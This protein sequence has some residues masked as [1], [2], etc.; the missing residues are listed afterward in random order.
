VPLRVVARLGGSVDRTGS[1][2]ENGITIT[3]GLIAQGEMADINNAAELLSYNFF[4]YDV[5]LNSLLGKLQRCMMG[6]VFMTELAT[7]INSQADRPQPQ[8]SL[9]LAK[10]H[11]ELLGASL[12]HVQLFNEG[13]Q[14][15]RA[16]AAPGA[17]WGIDK[18][19]PVPV[20]SNVVVRK[21][22]RGLGLGSDLLAAAENEARAWKYPKLFL[23]VDAEDP[24]SRSLYESR[25]YKVLR[26]RDDMSFLVP[27]RRF[28]QLKKVKLLL[29][30]KTLSGEPG[31]TGSDQH[32][33]LAILDVDEELAG[34]K[35]KVDEM[36]LEEHVMAKMILEKKAKVAEL[37]AQIART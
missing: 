26:Q 2:L 21:D 32:H 3:Q 13:T 22:K 31:S 24:R 15:F 33:A 25:G 27:G 19:I 8:C 29:M 6:G 4:D 1:E 36:N 37:D 5:D 10:Q 9:L 20:L 18:F 11:E 30:S 35:A 28:V 12:V 23:F 7:T 17:A 14:E 16:M 34:R